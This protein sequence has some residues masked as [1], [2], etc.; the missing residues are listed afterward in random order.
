MVAMKIDNKTLK[1]PSAALL[2]AAAV[3]AAMAL[4]AVDA[5]ADETVERT[6]SKGTA[7]D[8]TMTL[9]GGEEGTLFESLRVEGEDRVRIRFDRPALN[10]VLDAGNAPGLDWKSVQEVIGRTGVDLIAPYL[11][12]SAGD[13]FNSSWR[14]ASRKRDRVVFT[15]NAEHRA[16]GQSPA[17]GSV[18]SRQ[19]RCRLRT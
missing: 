9:Q 5:V 12:R 4:T 6:E 10:L 2:V 15:L 3:T 19:R 14:N 18:A 16:D 7:P 8:T 13:T 17:A 1:Q 11:A